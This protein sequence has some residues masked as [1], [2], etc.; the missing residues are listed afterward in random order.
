MARIYSD[1]SVSAANGGEL[2]WVSPG[3]MVQPFE[4][5]FEQLALSEVSQPVATQYGVHIIE[6]LDRRKKNITDQMIRGR[7][8]N[9]LRR[10]RAEREFQQWVRELK[11][12]AYIEYVSKPA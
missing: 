5:A 12:Q 9:I 8:D 2:G 1:D 3:E 6:V 11:E 7:A 4:Q 10:R